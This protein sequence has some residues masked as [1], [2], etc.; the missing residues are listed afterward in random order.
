MTPVRTILC[1]P[2]PLNLNRRITTT[3]VVVNLMS[4]IEVIPE[5]LTIVECFV[6]QLP[7]RFLVPPL[8]VQ[9]LQL[10]QRPICCHH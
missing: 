10:I 8:C 6:H 5:D 7:T 4:V 3:I 9:P 1:S 2:R